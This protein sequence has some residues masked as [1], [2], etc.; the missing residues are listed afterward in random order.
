VIQRFQTTRWSHVLAARDGA[1][2]RARR[3]LEELCQTYWYPLFA[4]VRRWGYRPEE[5]E[6]L[7]QAYFSE[8]LEKKFLR[9]VDRSAGRFRSFL[10]VSLK[11][12][13]SH[14][15][16]RAHALKRGGGVKPI[17]LDSSTHEVRYGEIAS[18]ELTPEQ[19][20]DRHWALTVLDRAIDRLRQCAEETGTVHKFEI[21]K[22]YLTGEAGNP[23]YAE[24]AAE[25]EMTEVGARSALH[26]LRRRFA[27]MLHAVIVDTVADPAEA[28]DEIRYLL[29]VL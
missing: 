6:D 2:T 14:E 11:H 19:V 10:L 17:S 9:S 23:P 26:R 12:F 13:L 4:F 7:T 22:P 5:A 1:D 15:R 16:D 24:I 20:F 25:L 8:L 27:K 3:A 28:D 29:S 18:H 21:L